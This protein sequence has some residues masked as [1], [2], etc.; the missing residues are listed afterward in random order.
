MVNVPLL[1]LRIIGVTPLALNCASVMATGLVP[2]VNDASAL[3]GLRLNVPV[4]VS[5]VPAGVLPVLK[6]LSFTCAST[7]A[8]KPSRP[9]T[10]TK[11]LTA[12]MSKLSVLIATEMSTPP[13]AV[14]PVSCTRK[15]SAPRPRPL[16]LR[17]GVKVNKPALMSTTLIVGVPVM[18]TPLSRYTPSA[19]SG[20]LVRMTL[21]KV[22]A[23]ASLVSA[24]PKCAAVTTVGVSSKIVIV[25]LVAV[26]ASFTAFTVIATVLLS[27]LV[28]M[29]PELSVDSMVRVSF[30]LKLRLPW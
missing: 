2:S 24:K 15:L 21:N 25:L 9:V 10:D 13:F 14:P 3:A 26:G 8:A 12:V 17:A 6:S 20:R 4:A 30:P 5:P 18:A 29:F 28:K 11:S 16:T 22:W 23:D 27:V 19:A 7:P 1:P